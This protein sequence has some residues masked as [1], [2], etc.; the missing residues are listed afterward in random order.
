MKT[1]N[2]IIGIVCISDLRGKALGV[3]KEG[4]FNCFGKIQ[5]KVCE[6]S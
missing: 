2:F 6:K 3:I 5:A 4:E 1:V